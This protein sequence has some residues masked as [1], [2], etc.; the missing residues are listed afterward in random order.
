MKVSIITVCYNS[1]DTIGD[2]IKSVA[3]QSYPN[4]E[5]IIV[6]G[7]S[8]DQTINIVK[9]W[10]DRVNIFISEPDRG[11][12]DAMNKGIMQA[13]GEIIGVLNS[14]DVFEA[15]SVIAEIAQVFE[16]NA[17]CQCVYGDLLYVSSQDMNKVLRY[18][19]SGNFTK[20]CFYYGWMPPHPTF[21]V[22]RSVFDRFGYYLAELQVA[23]DYE[24][25]LRI[26]GKHQQPVEYIKKVLVRMR[27]G[28]VSNKSI[29]NRRRSFQENYTAWRVN[30]LKPYPFTI[31]LK[32]LRKLGQYVKRGHIRMADGGE[33]VKYR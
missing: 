17:A 31:P 8:T 4:I 10:G 16:D 13:T 25:M 23:A 6:D 15:N 20:N 28:G 32:I 22:R 1:E 14:D 24:F 18:W 26:L 12:Y 21:Y 3:S 11:I 27:A 2:T 9:S 29:V 33:G 5:Y 30:E 7:G 19:E